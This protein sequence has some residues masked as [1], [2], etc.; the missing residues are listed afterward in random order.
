MR[1]FSIRINVTGCKNLSAF[2]IVAAHETL[3]GF[4]GRPS[5]QLPA[6]RYNRQLKN[7][8]FSPSLFQCCWVQ[9][10][11]IVRFVFN[12]A[13]NPIITYILHYNVS[14]ST[15]ATVERPSSHSVNINIRQICVE[16]LLS[17]VKPSLDKCICVWSVLVLKI[18]GAQQWMHCSSCLFVDGNKQLFTA[19]LSFV[20]GPKWTSSDSFVLSSTC[21][22]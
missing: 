7:I 14:L 2:K 19:S 9:Y 13:V 8:L 11:Y 15:F 18:R 16:S 5:P 10:W 4:V 6:I 12:I 22:W 3:S 20:I 17:S 1:K 21:D